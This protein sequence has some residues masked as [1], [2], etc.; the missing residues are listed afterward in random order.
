MR[1]F[2]DAEP[3]I[4]HGPRNWSPCVSE[5]TKPTSSRT[6]LM[7]TFWRTA[8]KSIPGTSVSPR[9]RSPDGRFRHERKGG[10]REEEPV[11]LFCCP[12]KRALSVPERLDTPGIT[13]SDGESS[14]RILL[15]S[16]F[17][18]LAGAPLGLFQQAARCHDRRRGVESATPLL[19]PS[20]VST[21]LWDG[22]E[23]DGP[24]GEAFP[25]VL[26]GAIPLDVP[27]FTGDRRLFTLCPRVPLNG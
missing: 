10:H 3:W 27:K 18:K 23:S 25:N 20:S 17:S 1:L 21:S 16:Q 9:N 11:C 24:Q 6:S 15:T 13:P 22:R 2:G 19:L 5:G 7:G 4:G 26:R 12:P 14:P 8:L